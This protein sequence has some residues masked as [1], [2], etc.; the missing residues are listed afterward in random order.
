MFPPA[1]YIVS[2]I[3]MAIIALGMINSISL[4][5]AKLNNAV[6]IGASAPIIAKAFKTP[7]GKISY[8]FPVSGIKPF[9]YDKNNVFHKEYNVIVRWD[10]NAVAA[11]YLP[12]V[13]WEY[14]ATG[15]GN[16]KGK[17][18]SKRP[19]LIA[20]M[21]VFHGGKNSENKG[22]I[23][24]NEYFR[25]HNGTL[26]LG[27]SYREIIYKYKVTIVTSKLDEH[28][29]IVEAWIKA[30]AGIS[31][32][33]KLYN[34][35]NAGFNLAQLEAGVKAKIINRHVVGNKYVCTVEFA[36][37]TYEILVKYVAGVYVEA[38]LSVHSSSPE[39]PLGHS[40]GITGNA[41][42][43]TFFNLICKGTYRAYTDYLT[44]QPYTG[45]YTFNGDGTIGE[46]VFTS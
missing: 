4:A 13:V 16:E 35:V 24:Y 2:I 12:A 31:L 45:Y 9:L 43:D 14:Q 30:R 10:K 28:E 23:Q 37:P 39:P 25:L 5:N 6:L 42:K 8:S 1:K 18:I 7:S 3:I 36:I 21:A 11:V 22:D 46:L 40:V 27:I 29:E 32:S 26:A 20:L 34:F 44:M 15:Q 19:S 41:A 38:D 33:L 17:I